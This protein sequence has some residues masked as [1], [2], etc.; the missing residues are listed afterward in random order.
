MPLSTDSRRYLTAKEASKLVS[1]VT[2]LKPEVIIPDLNQ[3]V[4]SLSFLIETERKDHWRKE[5]IA[6]GT[7][8]FSVLVVMTA[9]LYQIFIV[10]TNSCVSFC[11]H[12]QLKSLVTCPPHY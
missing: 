10:W 12:D 3:T 11:L 2:Y 8:L 1:G 6:W 9:D 4:F 5:D 7:G